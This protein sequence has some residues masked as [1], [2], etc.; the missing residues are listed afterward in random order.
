VP[1]TLAPELRPLTEV[2]RA[3]ILGLRDYVDKNGFQSVVLGLSGGIDSALSAVLAVHALGAERVV[4]VTLPSEFTGRQSVEDAEEL[5]NRLGVRLLNVPIQE[6]VDVYTKSLKPLFAERKEDV[7]EENLQARARGNVL[8]ALSNKFGW[9]VLATGNKSEFS[10]G[11]CT[12]YGDMAGGFAV[13][14][15]VPKTLVYTLA[16]HVNEVAAAEGGTP[17]IPQSTLTRPP[18]AELKPDQRD[19]DTLPPYTTLDPVLAAYVEEDLAPA[20]LIARG[21]DPE[22]VSR[23]VAMVDCNEYK[24]R[25]AP[26]GIR[27]TP[28]AFGRDRR[29]PITN[30]YHPPIEAAQ[31]DFEGK[32][33]PAARTRTKDRGSPQNQGA[34]ARN[35]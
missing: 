11:Y 6:I 5:A 22:V 25:Q 19:E 29:L 20:E 8:M 17:P 23:V 30:L 27:I 21:F 7:T 31:A 14:K 15:D 34:G 1:A 3:I 12:L 33:G 28:R 35:T 32:T 24:R 9:L 10:V 18:T 4:G 16:R 2:H 13:L 26:P